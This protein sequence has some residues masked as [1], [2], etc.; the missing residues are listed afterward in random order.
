MGLR[1]GPSGRHYSPPAAAA[2]AG[3]PRGHHYACTTAQVAASACAPAA[4][5]EEALPQITASYED[6][7]GRSAKELKTILTERGIGTSDCVEKTDLARKIMQTC[8][9]TTYYKQAS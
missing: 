5:P 4:A 8:A 9:T 6:L 7:M 3:P 2:A 1:H